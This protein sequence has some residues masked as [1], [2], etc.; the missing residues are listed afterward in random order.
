MKTLSG[1]QESFQWATQFTL[2]KKILGP[3]DS[4]MD[5]F[6]PAHTV[7][8][9]PFSSNRAGWHKGVVTPVW[10]HGEVGILPFKT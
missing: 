7:V 6:L 2:R 8:F 5:Y 10:K 1:R 9:V 4:T 3:L